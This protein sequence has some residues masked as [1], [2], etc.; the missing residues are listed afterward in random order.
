MHLSYS[1]T[2]KPALSLKYADAVTKG[3]AASAAVLQTAF[4]NTIWLEAPMTH[5]ILIGSVIVLVAVSMW[6]RAGK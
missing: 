6:Q 4:L 2:N 5:P 3:M 1:F